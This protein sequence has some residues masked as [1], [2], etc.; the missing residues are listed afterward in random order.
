MLALNLPTFSI[1]LLD[2]TK[3]SIA[4]SNLT[5]AI[6]TMRRPGAEGNGWLKEKKIEV[7]CGRF[8]I[9]KGETETIVTWLDALGV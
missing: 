6:P 7:K 5:Y 2:L 3:R 8:Y 4:L 9:S 1:V